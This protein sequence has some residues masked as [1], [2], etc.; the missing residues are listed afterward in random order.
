MEVADLDRIEQELTMCTGLK[1]IIDIVFCTY[2]LPKL[3]PTDQARR[4][5]WMTN[6]WLMFP[7]A[8][9]LRTFPGDWISIHSIYSFVPTAQ[10]VC[11]RV[12]SNALRCYPWFFTLSTSDIYYHVKL[13]LIDKIIYSLFTRHILIFL[14]TYINFS[15]IILISFNIGT[16]KS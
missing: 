6:R 9:F 4:T 5:V 10:W 16:S 1:L 7:V 2:S 12:T 14:N 15:Q 3:P 11:F 8:K 13:F